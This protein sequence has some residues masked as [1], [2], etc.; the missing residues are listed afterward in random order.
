[1]V[2]SLV[3]IA[4]NLTKNLELVGLFGEVGLE[5]RDGKIQPLKVAHVL[6]QVQSTGADLNGKVLSSM[7]GKGLV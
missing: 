1:M 3:Q 5:Y 6:F 7:N 4:F 2:N